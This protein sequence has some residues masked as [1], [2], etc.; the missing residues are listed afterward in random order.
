MLFIEVHSYNTLSQR[1]SNKKNYIL[2]QI[3]NVSL[4]ALM[5]YKLQ[6]VL[7]NKFLVDSFNFMDLMQ[8]SGLSSPQLTPCLIESVVYSSGRLDGNPVNLHNARRII[9]DPDFHEHE[10]RWMEMCEEVSFS[11]AL[12]YLRT[13]MFIDKDMVVIIDESQ[14]HQ[15][16]LALYRYR[17][18][19]V[20]E[21]ILDREF[22]NS[23]FHW[24][25]AVMDDLSI[26]PVQFPE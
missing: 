12:R 22:M 6:V 21:S 4:L 13:R 3:L 23:I 2:S 7:A 19:D 24:S 14:L 20:D 17:S 8:S 9:A 18:G 26:S 15:L 1:H 16:A 25:E 11:S 10:Q 5:L